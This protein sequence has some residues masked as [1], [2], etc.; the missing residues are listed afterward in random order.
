MPKREQERK[1]KRTDPAA[2]LYGILQKHFRFVRGRDNMPI[3]ATPRAGR[4]HG[5]LALAGAMADMGLKLGLELGTRYGQSARIWLDVIPGLE[6]VCVDPY[7]AYHRTNQAEQEKVYRDAQA[8]LAEYRNVALL[9]MTSRM[10]VPSFEDGSLDFVYIDGDHTFDEAVQD[11]IQFVPKVRTGG[12]VMVHDY[13]HF[14]LSGVI[15]A[16]DAYTHCHRI[17]PWYVTRDYEPTAFWQRGSER[18]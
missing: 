3:L 16:V 5:R 4:N 2:E 7:Q 17:E 8:N 13:C 1:R 6:L 15:Q 18:A 14:R 10:A 12:L 11:I 9:R